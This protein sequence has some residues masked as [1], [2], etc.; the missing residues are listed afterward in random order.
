MVEE[1]NRIKR[2]NEEARITI[3]RAFNGIIN[4]A[5]IKYE[6]ENI[7][8]FFDITTPKINEFVNDRLVENR[9]IKTTFTLVIEMKK[10]E[11]G[12]ADENEVPQAHEII[13]KF[14]INSD[15]TAI[16]NQ[17][18]SNKIVSELKDYFTTR[19]EEVKTNSSGWKFHK[20]ISIQIRTVKHK[21]LRG[22]SHI[23]L[24]SWIANK[25]ACV[26][27]KNKDN[28][29]FKWA[30]LSCI[31]N[32]QINQKRINEVSQYEKFADRLNWDGINFPSKI[33]DIVRFEKNNEEYCINLFIVDGDICPYRI[34]KD[35]KDKTIINLLLIEENEKSHYVWIKSMSRLMNCDGKNTQHICMNCLQVFWNEES[36]NNHK[37]YC[38]KNECSKIV[39][40]ISK[41]VVK[42][43]KIVK[44]RNDSV[45]FK[46]FG[47]M[48]KVPFVF[49]ADFES[50]LL[51]V[52]GASNDPNKSYTEVFQ[53]HKPASFCLYRVCID[54]KYNKM[55]EYD[56]NSE[57]IVEDFLKTLKSS[58]EEA[59]EI[60]QK[61]VPMNLTEEEEKQY[62]QCS[63]C[64]ICK[65]EIYDDVEN[66]HKVRD[67]CHITGQYRGPAHNKCN[68]QYRYSYKFPCIFHNLKGYDSH[69]IIKTLGKIVKN[70]DSEVGC[71]PTNKEKYLTFNW[72]NIQ[73]IDSIQFMASSLE[74]LA[75]NL[76]YEDKKHTRK[77]FEKD[78]NRTAFVGLSF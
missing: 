40:P 36:L 51:P 6:T 54:Q 56:I 14:Y 74:D 65:S 62:Q 17:F 78:A 66:N 20:T 63:K 38:D 27:I 50:Y 75:K 32:D 19:I 31:F 73:F 34:S 68:L 48:L 12:F 26:N 29:C 72:D 33:S 76:I 69:H 44:Q 58:T 7:D 47:K 45:Q 30:V 21:P 23:D 25:K 77:Y 52:D 67:H 57:N 28:Q 70:T 43:G 15:P 10:E 24:P 46:N 2:Q 41:P 8:E 49:Y 9:N 64:H 16:M 42:D 35:N 1:M 11:L 3:T 37:S 59:T 22:R 39:M 60:M 13:S 61:I 18:E 71:I 53:N 55:Y 5:E 4:D